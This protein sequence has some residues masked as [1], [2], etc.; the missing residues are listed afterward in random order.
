MIPEIGEFALIIS[1]MLSVILA[2]APMYGAATRNEMWMS[3]AKPLAAGQFLFI[4]ISFICLGYAFAQD[5]FSVVYVAQHSN[6][7]MPIQF[8]L[9]AIWGGHEGSLLLW[10]LILCGWTFAVS[11]FSK[12]LP[13]DM[14]ARVLSVMGIVAT[15][16][17]SFLLITSS[18][19]NRYLP[20]FPAD[21]A[22]LNPLLQDFGLIVHPPMLYMGYVGFSV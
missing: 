3:F 6:S 1:L 12:A 9:S 4:T 11:R 21:G 19:F 17:I 7:Q 15:G 22:D 14:L 2:V 20:R 5:D 8:K 10:A 13:L 16:F 18:P